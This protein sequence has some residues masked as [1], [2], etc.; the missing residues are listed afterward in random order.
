MYNLAQLLARAAV[1]KEG[2]SFYTSADDSA[3]P[4]LVS[5]AQLQQSALQKSRLLSTVD[6]VLISSI[7]LLYFDTQLE[8]I[9]WFWA[10]TLAGLLPAISGSFAHDAAQRT[11]HLNHLQTLLKQPTILTFESLLPEFQGV[12]GLRLCTIESLLNKVTNFPADTGTTPATTKCADDPAVL[13]LTSGS[14]GN[15][16]AV[17]LRHGQLLAAIQGKITHHLTQPG[18]VF[19]NWVG[20]DHVA[21][22]CEV[23]LHAGKYTCIQ[24]F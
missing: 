7:V 18:D 22:L 14:T 24:P 21:S 4:R 20:L 3:K 5:Y 8:T 6:G 16:K 9:E 11:K 10:A 19:L 17:P 15:A 23:H 12:K 13:M 2:L 1:T